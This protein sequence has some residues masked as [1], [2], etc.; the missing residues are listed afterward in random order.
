M[1][2]TIG[3]REYTCALD[4]SVAPR[5]RR[6]LNRPAELQLALVADGA[7]FTA[8]AEGARV[9]WQRE[10]GT[11]LFTGYVSAA[12]EAEYLGWGERG[13]IYRYRVTALGDEWLLDLKRLPSRAAF[14]ARSA[15]EILKELTRALLP[16]LN[17]DQVEDVASPTAY[18]GD[19]GRR[20][21]EHAAAIALRARGCYRA[22]DGAV[23]LRPAGAEEFALDEADAA[24]SPDGLKLM[25]PAG[26]LNDVTM[27]GRVEPR[28]H[29][30]DYF[31]G[32]GMTLDFS[33]S[34]Q[35]FARALS[36]FV[37]EEFR[38]TALDPLWWAVSGEAAAL[39]VSGGKLQIAGGPVSVRLVEQVELGGGLLLQHGEV[40]FT[41]ASTGLLGGLFS[42]GTD[43]AH[44]VAAFR[45]E[46]SG[47]ACAISA[48]INGAAAGTSITTVAGRRYALTTRMY[49]T[50]VYRREQ[51]FHSS[52]HPAG[53]GRGGAIVP[54]NAHLVL[55]VHEID[56]GNPASLA[57]ASIVLYDGVVTDVPAFCDYLLVNAT[58]MQC[59][60]GCT[61]LVRGGDVEVASTMPNQPSRVRLTG[62]VAEGGECR[63]N[64]YAVF[65]YP[66]SVPVPQE[67]V[68]VSYRSAGRAMAR[69]TDPASA[70]A[71]A[72]GDDDGARSAV[73]EVAQPPARTSQE[74]AHAALA[75]LDDATQPAW[76]GEYRTW[77]DFLP[78]TSGGAPAPDVWPG[79]SL[80]VAVPS[81][82]AEFRA[83]VREVEIETVALADDRSRYRLVFANE[84]ADPLALA[85]EG[86]A[87]RELPDVTVADAVFPADLTGAEVTGITSTTVTIDTGCNAPAGGGFE[88]RRSDYGWSAEHDRNL[89]GR[90]TARSFTVARLTRVETWYVR[91]YDAAGAYSR[92]SCALHVDYPF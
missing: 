86:A 71:R 85:T 59:A 23:A 60:I 84:A 80:H 92:H 55:E 4:T 88:V 40:E 69:V 24:F 75:M 64:D 5:V 17:T 12:P 41:A 74:C 29:V 26:L 16:A 3:D 61:R 66:A 54:A 15:G 36:T 38:G 2:L 20:W 63:V 91:Q 22:H 65:F 28:V 53:N 56:P 73:W 33:L 45:V 82:A 52:V 78:K 46:P 1:R 39:S 42:G 8:P 6:R 70:A 7:D 13:N 76:A 18:A 11:K 43:A 44:A 67:A 58:A 51:T 77:S 57:T 35:P 34:H 83:I 48:V 72:R 9:V 81:R 79:D 27:I 19:G 89:V 21:S 32:D 47:G 10:D 31:L 25:Q 30:K 37:E 68:R 50:E 49:T 90:F 62:P 87:L 14:V